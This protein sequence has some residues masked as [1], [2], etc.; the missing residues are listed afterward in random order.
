MAVADISQIAV[1][2]QQVVPG[3]RVGGLQ[4]GRAAVLGLCILAAFIRRMLAQPAAGGAKHAVRWVQEGVA[5][6]LG[7][8]FRLL[9]DPKN[10]DSVVNT[11]AATVRQV[12]PQRIWC[13]ASC[14]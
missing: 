5:A 10:S 6:V 12:P 9:A 14:R 13:H 4:E 2:L 1:H 7:L 11:A 3:V 8:C